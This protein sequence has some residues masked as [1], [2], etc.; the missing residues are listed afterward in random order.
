[1]T[2]EGEAL[3]AA[4]PVRGV[5]PTDFGGEDWGVAAAKGALGGGAPITGCIEEDDDDGGEA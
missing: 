2:S 3:C 4:V 1:M 5:E